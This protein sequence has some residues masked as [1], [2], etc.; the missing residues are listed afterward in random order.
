MNQFFRFFVVGIVNFIVDISVFSFLI[1][2][3][4]FGK[5]VVIFTFFS[6][7]VTLFSV[8]KFISFLTANINSFFLNRIWTFGSSNKNTVGL[9]YVLFLF[10]SL[11]GVFINVVVFSYVFGYMDRFFNNSFLIANLSAVLGSFF[12]MVWNFFG[13]KILV[14]KK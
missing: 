6:I 8:F 11:I 2:F 12:A 5:D 4:P 3:F 14:F 10:V 7:V 1:Y 13:Y 9:E